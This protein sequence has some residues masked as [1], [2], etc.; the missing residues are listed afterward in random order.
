LI[1][2]K[3]WFAPEPLLEA[4]V[5]GQFGT[6]QFE[7]HRAILGG[8]V[9]AIYVAHPADTQQRLQLIRP[10]YRADS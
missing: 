5:G 6:Q 10:E 7:R 3:W 4:G 8:V 9:G 2:P 1:S